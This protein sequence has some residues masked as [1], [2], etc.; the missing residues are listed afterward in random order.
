MREYRIIVAEAAGGEWAVQET[1]FDAGEIQETARLITASQPLSQLPRPVG[2]L[3]ACTQAAEG[4][5][6]RHHFAPSNF[7]PQ[8]L[9]EEEE[10][11]WRSLNVNFWM[12]DLM[13][14]NGHTARRC[15]VTRR[16]QEAYDAIRAEQLSR[17]RVGNP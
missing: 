17:R 4:D 1:D 10:R 12:L 2:F 14:R 15:E 13:D 16:M 11:A 7:D 5:L 9:T 8:N 6:V 3:A